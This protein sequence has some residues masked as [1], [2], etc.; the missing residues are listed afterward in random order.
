M[1]FDSLEKDF[2]KRPNYQSLLETPFLT[3]AEANNVDMAAFISHV[4]D[5]LP[6]P[7]KK[8]DGKRKLWLTLHYT[9]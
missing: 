1:F 9:I 4:L 3:A 5:D 7:E 2:Q 6:L 8:S